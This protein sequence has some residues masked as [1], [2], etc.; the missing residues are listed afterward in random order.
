MY[1]QIKL[2]SKG[3]DEVSLVMD[4]TARRLLVALLSSEL[5]TG[6]R[7]VVRVNAYVG[8]LSQIPVQLLGLGTTPHVAGDCVGDRPCRVCADFRRQ[9]EEESE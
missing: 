3:P 4:Q 1:L 7:V 8:E 2:D 5:F 6:D 9:R